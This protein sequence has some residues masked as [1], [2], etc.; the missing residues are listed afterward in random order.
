[1]IDKFKSR[2]LNYIDN[3]DFS[4]SGGFVHIGILPELIG[5]K[6]DDIIISLCNALGATSIRI[7]NS[8]FTTDCVP[9]RV[10]I[11]TDENDIIE[12]ISMEV[13]FRATKNSD[14]KCGNDIYRKIKELKEKES[15]SDGLK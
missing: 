14:I 11:R 3:K 7:S 10:T 9:N 13:C 6:I 15:N 8:E 4:S 1:M 2:Y 12:S 5:C